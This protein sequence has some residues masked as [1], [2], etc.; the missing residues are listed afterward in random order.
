MVRLYHHLLISLVTTYIIIATFTPVLRIMVTINPINDPIPA[1]RLSL[2]LFLAKIYSKMN[3]PTNGPRITP[4]ILPTI[5]PV[6]PPN[7][8][9]IIP[10][11]VPP[12]TFT[13]KALTMLSMKVE[14]ND[15]MKRISNI[16]GVITWN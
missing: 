16:A 14:S 5:R 4:R 3:A 10:Q 12:I 6:K 1:F 8:A 13:P 11:I 15:T 9:P 7:K 2:K